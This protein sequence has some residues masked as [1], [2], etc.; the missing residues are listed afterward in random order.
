MT[1]SPLYS[2]SNKFPVY[3]GRSSLEEAVATY[4]G[5]GGLER[6]FRLGWEAAKTGQITSR[7]FSSGTLE[8]HSFCEG[9][10]AH[11]RYASI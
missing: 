10:L 6:P 1:R 11:D 4:K 8:H 9:Y 5:K 3:H 2:I 7:T